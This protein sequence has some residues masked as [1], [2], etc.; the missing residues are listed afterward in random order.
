MRRIVSI[1]IALVLTIAAGAQTLKITT[2][3]GTKTYDASN[4]TSSSPATFSNGTSM[5]IGSDTYTLSDITSMLVV[6]SSSS[7]VEAN[8]VNIVYNGSTATVTMADNVAAYVTA[9]VSGAHV[10]ITQSNTAAIDGDEITYVLSG[11]TTNGSLTLAGS[12]KCTISLDG[13]TLTNPSGAAINITNSKRIQ[14]SAKKGTESTLTDG[15]G[16]QK[17]C[18]YSKGQLQLQGNGTLNVIGNYKHGIKSASYIT[19]K[20]LT[21]NITSTVSDGINSEEYFQMKS[22]TVTISGV[23]DDGIQCDLGGT[24]STGETTDHEDED[25]GNVYLEGGTLTITTTAAASKGIKADGSMTVSDGTYTIS[26]TGSAAWDSDDS[27]VKAC[28]AMSAD[29]NLT[30]SGG[31]LTLSSTGAGG[32]AISVDGTLSISGGVTSAITTGQI[33]YCQST[34]NTTIRTTT[35][36]STTERLDDALKTS[37][38]AIKADGAMT[39]NGGTTYAKASYH[40][41]VET[42]STLD[43]TGGVIYA[44]SADD[45]INSAST[46]TLSGGYVGAYSTGND[47]IDSNGN[48]YIKGATVFAYTTKSSPEVAIDANTEGGYKLYV[49]SGTVY[50]YPSLES[51]SSLTLSC[52]TASLSTS[53]WYSFTQ[54][55]TAFAFKVPYSG[56][57]IVSGG[58]SLYSVSKSNGTTIFD[59]YGATDATVSG[60]SS[61]SLSSYSGGAS[62][63]GGFP[64]GG[65]GPGG[66]H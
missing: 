38:K 1:L 10:S 19:I 65:G 51:G 18:I 49:Q 7:D 55:G 48:L 63:G 33:A 2:N 44:Y 50:V 45:A 61:V 6:S 34:S 24:T 25:T 15:S 20:N 21:L 57:W 11:S 14:L 16:S 41:A 46:M 53:N 17:A 4:V 36:S 30:I 5:T 60:G 3:S 12:Y 43:V 27:E 59:G 9:E 8:T 37:P 32:K 47:A 39:I 58:S 52:Y 66:W 23:G 28:A 13:L 42:K 26:T 64:G 54:D 35:S 40:E 29:G 62:G 22:G 56:T 31:T